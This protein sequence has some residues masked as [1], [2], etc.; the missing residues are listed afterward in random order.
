MKRGDV[1]WVSLNPSRGHEQAGFR[2]VVIVSPEAFNVASGVPIVLP[3][4]NGGAFAQR[5]GFAV[6]LNDDTL[7]ITGLIRCD[8]PRALDLRERQGQ[9]LA[10]LPMHLVNEMVAK[11]QVLFA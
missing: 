10:S 6:V 11:V 8:Q 1:Y 5:I 2:P 9:Y 4:T 7:P 3:I